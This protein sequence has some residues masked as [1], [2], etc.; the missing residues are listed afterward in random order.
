MGKGKYLSGKQLQQALFKRTEGYAANV[1]AIYNDSLGKIIDIVKGT[2]LED[3]VSFSFSEYGYTDEV[4]PIL[5][6]MYSRVYQAI[7]T[8]V[9]KEWLFASENNDELVKSVFGDSSIEDN[10]FA[11]YFMRNR[12]AMDA[13]FARKTQ[14]LDLSQKVWKYTSQYKGEL[15]GTLDLAIGEGTPANQLASKIQQY[16]QDPDRWYRRFRI[17]VG[18]DENGNP[19]YGRIWKRRI[20]D[21]EDGVYKWINDDPKHYHPG[22]GVYRSSYRNAQRLAR[23]ETNIAYRSA[24]YERWAQLDFVVGVE[25][26]L[27]NNHPEP[28]ICDQL[29]GIY[30]KDFKWTGW[31]PNCRCYMVP[32]L[33]TAEDLD[34]MLDKIMDGEEPGDLSVTSENTVSEVPEGFK[35]WIKDP[36]TQERIEKAEEK[37]TL[38]YFI[39]DNKQIVNKAIHGLS[40]EEQKALSY[41]DLLVDPLAILK[42]FDAATL[43]QLYTAVKSKLND[44]LKGTLDSQKHTLE[45][46]I[47]WVKQHRKYNTWQEAA[48]AYQKALDNVNRQIEIRNVRNS[49]SGI[50]QFVRDHPK[51]KKVKA[52]HMQ[53][54]EALTNGDVVAAKNLIAQAD[55]AILQYNKEQAKKI[56]KLGMKSSTDIEKYCDEHRTYESPVVDTRS[57]NVFQDRS[58]GEVSDAWINSKYEAKR[59][60]RGYTNGT[61][62]DINESYWKHH[63]KHQYGELMDEI[64]DKCYLSEDTVLRR[65]CSF[66]EMRSIFGDTF[67]NLIDAMDIDGL[68]AVAGARGVNEGF[69]S[70]SWD[71]DG[72]FWKSVDLRIFAPKGTQAF[73]AKP[74]SGFGDGLGADWDGKTASKTLRKGAEN[75]TIVHRGYEYRFVRAEKYAGSH[76]SKITI[77]IELLTRDKRVVK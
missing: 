32:V 18:E 30:P 36:K 73:Y 55:D 75:E 60:V 38:P 25:I 53:I 66:S 57:F 33:A 61:Y 59:A 1:R 27:S 19:I 49:A 37:G 65:G 48:D 9:E 77:Y 7:R 8:G 47:N 21:K 34:E 11:K 22:Q 12:E 29:K 63:K 43:D 17:K 3:G 26:K 14:G 20:F 4:Q 50:D 45:F 15:E 68:N 58:I 2:E 64:L 70:T 69:I 28:D 39:K 42:K 74:V 13:F 54:Q 76:G 40:P 41:A 44:M 35:R 67:G 23:S 71:M 10:H 24:D 5:R 51:S 46:E 31:H 6:N 56:A 72:G 62:D 52:L 16:L